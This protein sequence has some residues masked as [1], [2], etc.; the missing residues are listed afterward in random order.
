MVTNSRLRR[1]LAEACRILDSCR[2]VHGYGHVSARAQDGKTVLISPRK[3]VG[4]VR[5]PREILQIDMDG[6]TVSGN[7]Q[8]RQKIQDRSKPPLELFLHTEIYRL[9]PDVNAICRTHGMFSL[10]MSVLRRPLRTVHELAVAV[11]P[12]VP[13]FDNPE[14]IASP[15][16]GQRLA[17]ALGTARGLLMRGNGALSVGA[18]VEEAVVNAILMETSA[19]VQWRALCV[20][21]PAWIAGDKDS[22]E[23]AKLARREYEAVQRPWQYYLARSRD[24]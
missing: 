23:F 24:K 7:K 6:N 10:V 5:S 18:T 15:A 17:E 9:R 14:L 22:G 13:L 4:L 19:E 21:E 16:M 20:G 2:L 1:N 11:G 8:G 12:V 3:G